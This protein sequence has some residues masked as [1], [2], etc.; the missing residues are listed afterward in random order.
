MDVPLDV[1]AVNML[2]CKICDFDSETQFELD[3]HMK[4]LHDTIP[5]AK[6]DQEMVTTSVKD[7][8][9]CEQ[10]AFNCSSNAQLEE[11]AKSKHCDQHCT[12]CEEIFQTDVDLEWHIE[13]EH[14]PL[15]AT[16]I[17]DVIECDQCEYK[18]SFNAQLEDHA[19]SKHTDE[20]KYECKECDYEAH[21][22]A[23][24]WSHTIKQHPEK[25][26]NFKNKNEDNMML[27]IIVEQNSELIEEVETL[28]KDMKGAFQSLADIIEATMK[29]IKDETE[30]K[31]K[32]LADTVIKLHNK[33]SKCETRNTKDIKSQ[34]AKKPEGKKPEEKKEEVK[35]QVEKKQEEAKREDSTK[36]KPSYAAKAAAQPTAQAKELSNDNK[37]KKEHVPVNI[38]IVA[39]SHSR[40]LDYRVLENETRTK[41]DMATAYTVDE[42]DDAWYRKKNFLKVVLEKLQRKKYDTLIL[43][44]GCNEISNIKLPANPLPEAVKKW[45]EKVRISRTKMYELA[46]KSLKSNPGLKKVIILK[47]LPRYDPSS[48]DTNSIKAKLNIFGNTLYNSLWMEKGCTNNIVIE[49]QN[50]DCHGPLRVKRFGNPDFVG[51]DGKPWDGV[52]MRGRLAVTHYT[53]SIIRILSGSVPPPVFNSSQS[54]NHQSCPQALYQSRQ[55]YF[56]G[57]DRYSNNHNRVGNNSMHGQMQQNGDNY[58][59]CRQP[60]G[61]NVRVSNKFSYLGNY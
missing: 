1:E 40:N 16:E 8:I 49:D 50:L 6:V 60:Y 2:S 57:A 26:Y 32:T 33:I 46:E 21:F 36:E 29:N 7:A 45:E 24:I 53:N 51:Y 31:C 3:H 47:S 56:K 11:H 38:L 48:V 10:C 44:G 4:I 42:D 20:A 35:K 17:Q 9:K 54:D 37:S 58:T 14:E 41:V 25:A 28:K 12:K 52:H 18:C 55:L 30:G 59:N 22:M 19:K 5:L 34:E 13:T 27:K 15:K 61:Y 23:D 43:Q 39:D